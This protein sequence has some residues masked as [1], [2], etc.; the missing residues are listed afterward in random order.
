MTDRKRRRPARRGLGLAAALV[1]WAGPAAA[2]GSAAQAV[3]RAQALCEDLGGRFSVGEGAVGEIDLGPGRGEEGGDRGETLD[4]A[5]LVCE[6]AYSAF[7]GSGG[8]PLRVQVGPQAWEWQVEDWSMILFEGF[9]VLMLARDGG[10]CGG[11]GAQIC[12]EALKWDGQRFLTVGPA[13]DP[14]E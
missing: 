8:C 13:P 5:K 1:V 6:G 10:W 9:P 4:Y 11:A 12:F 14:A 3:E 7:C 2:A